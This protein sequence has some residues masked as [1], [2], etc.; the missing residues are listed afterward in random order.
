[1]TRLIVTS[2]KT[3]KQWLIPV[4]ETHHIKAL[5]DK[6]IQDLKHPQDSDEGVFALEPV[7]QIFFEH[8]TK[9]EWSGLI[10]TEDLEEIEYMVNP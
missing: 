4:D 5:D 2:A 6:A 10:V 9:D 7:C 8:L 1:M 3:G